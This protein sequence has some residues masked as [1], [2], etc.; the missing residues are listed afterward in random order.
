VDHNLWYAAAL[1]V[2]ESPVLYRKSLC[3]Y[4]FTMKKWLS[5]LWLVLGVAA[6]TASDYKIRTV[7]VL[8]LD[9]YPARITVEGIAIAADPYETDE[10]SYKAFDVKK[11]NSLGYFPVHV[12]I[13]N[14]SQYFLLVRTRNIVLI[15]ESAQQLFTIPATVVAGELFKGTNLDKLSDRAREA[16]ASRKLGTP[17]SDFTDKDLTNKLLEPGKVSDGFIFFFNPDPKKNLFSGST[18]FIPKLEEEGTRKSVGPFSIPLNPALT[19]AEKDA[20]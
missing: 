10:K 15:T 3:Y 1:P 20:K 7:K 8:P 16:P 12:I 6:L 5:I 2:A 14:T 18:L 17:L 9:S 11:L 4:V 19:P 13:Q